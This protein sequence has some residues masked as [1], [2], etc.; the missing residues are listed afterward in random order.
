MLQGQGIGLGLN[1]EVAPSSILLPQEAVDW[2]H[3]TLGNAPDE[4]EVRPREVRAPKGIP[5]HL[6]RAIDTKLASAMG[7]ARC[8][9]LA[10]VTYD[11]GAQGHLLAFV[12]AL[13]EAEGALARAASEALTFSGIEAGEMDVAF[14]GAADPI[15]VRLDRVGLR[16]DLPQPQSQPTRTV[17]APGNDLARPPKLR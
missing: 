17:T 15:L 8:A 7:L 16:F 14:F 5:D 3:G 1:L 13:P 12:A 9:Y 10:G 11:T 6:I 2:L 4:L